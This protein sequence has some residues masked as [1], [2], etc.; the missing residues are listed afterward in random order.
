MTI[1]AQWNRD[2][3]VNMTSGTI[4]LAPVWKAASLKVPGHRWGDCVTLYSPRCRESTG[5]QSL[6]PFQAA[7]TLIY[8]T[9][10]KSHHGPNGRNFLLT[11]AAMCQTDSTKPRSSGVLFQIRKIMTIIETNF[12]IFNRYSD[13]KMHLQWWVMFFF[14]CTK[15]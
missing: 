13:L 4:C 8:G 5:F 11:D 10:G 1:P 6:S 12:R 3:Q 15:N 7:V 2:L 9:P 14:F